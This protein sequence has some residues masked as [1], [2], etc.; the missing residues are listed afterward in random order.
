MYIG[1]L[2]R[3]SIEDLE[4]LFPPSTSRGALLLELFTDGKYFGRLNT[5]GLKDAYVMGEV[6]DAPIVGHSVPPTTT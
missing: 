4:E 5:C 3:S 2:E 1:R 6:V